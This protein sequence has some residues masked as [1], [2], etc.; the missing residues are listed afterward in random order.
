MRLSYF[1]QSLRGKSTAQ[2]VK[3]RQQKNIADQKTA[4][5]EQENKYARAI[6]DFVKN[7]FLALTTVEGQEQF[8]DYGQFSLAEDSTLRAL[9]D[10]AA[11][12]LERRTDL[13]PRIEAELYWIVGLNYRA[14]KEGDV[15]IRFLK[16]SLELQSTAYGENAE[17]S[18]RAAG[19]LAIAYSRAG[20]H[21]EAVSLQKKWLKICSDEL[22][23]DHSVTIKSMINLGL[24]Y[25]LAGHSDKCQQML[26]KTWE[27]QKARFDVADSQTLR[28]M[29]LM[30]QQCFYHTG[31]LNRAVEL[32]EQILSIR[33][34]QLGPNDPSTVQSMQDL[35]R[36]YLIAGEVEEALELLNQ[37]VAFFTEDVWGNPL[38][39]NQEHLATGKLLHGRSPIRSGRHVA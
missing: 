19:E 9:L 36:M 12:K 11:E 7:D 18:I 13:D 35:G 4:E 33:T 16:K 20:Q 32:S 29:R 10:R 17:E 37:S 3:A 25:D 6:A 22:G 28:T 15:A 5:A 24:F 27:I 30:A 34:E 26:E 2:L 38:P 21:H 14:L 39:N 1:S 23:Y 31:D 8:D